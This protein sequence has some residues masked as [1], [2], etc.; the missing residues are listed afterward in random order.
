MFPRLL[1]SLSLV[2]GLQISPTPTVAQT[3][4]E[5]WELLNPPSPRAQ[6]AAVWDPTGGRMLVIG[7]VGGA[8]LGDL[9]SYEPGGNRWVQQVPAGDRP[10]RL[11]GHSAVWDPGRERVLQFGGHGIGGGALWSY[12]PRAN[13]W[14]RLEPSGP[15]PPAR[16]YHSAVWDPSRE[17]MLVYGG[18]GPRAEIYDDL[19]VYDAREN[20]WIELPRPRSR[21]SP[22]FYQAAVWDPVGD[23]MLVFGGADLFQGVLWDDLWSYRPATN[24]WTEIAP[25][26]PRPSERLSHSMVWDAVGRRVLLFGGGC[27]A[28]CYNE[29]L[30]S[31]QP[32]TRS[33]QLQSAIGLAQ[34]GRRGGQSAVWDPVDGRLL[35][36]GG[37]SVEGMTNELWSYLPRTGTWT[38]YAGGWDRS[39]RS[40][41]FGWLAPAPRQGHGAAWDDGRG[42]LLVFGGYANE[43]FFDDLWRYSPHTQGWR[44]VVTQGEGPSARSNIGAAWDQQH[45]QLYLFGGFGPGGYLDELWRLDA[46]NRA[47]QQ[48]HP[49]GPTPLGREDLSLVWDPV[50]EQLLAYGGTRGDGGMGE[51]LA[52]RAATNSWVP[53][54][55]GSGP[56]RRIRHSAVWDP[57]GE[58]MLVFG[59]Y[60]G[61]EVGNYLDDLWGYDP[62]TDTWEQLAVGQSAPPPR[63]WHRSAWDAATERMVV[64]GGF[65]GGVD[66][67][68]DV[69]AY[70]PRADGW[71]E[72]HFSDPAPTPRAQHSAV[73]SDDGLLVYGGSGGN[74]NGE[75]WRLRPSLAE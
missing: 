38:Q 57:V 40:S 6:H 73:W 2:L 59:G 16:G 51:L 69:W 56:V 61:P 31:Y 9:W 37:A 55:Q 66:Y 72:L 27:G 33:W 64:V 13:Q 3:D 48:V 50:R 18:I 10:P 63:A 44:P 43:R 67:L 12:A 75:L 70:D 8:N 7:G 25:L 65:S 49:S 62:A 42:E 17:W 41:G 58:R 53:L 14:E 21:P 54:G 5:G 11:V 19:W 15:A 45:R 68:E 46:E 35:L 32:A 24:G 47:W 22:R 4:V 74:L 1:L 52:Y 34:P 71:V 23:Q 29:D 20:G 36:F 39:L 60:G 26:G 30:W 28:G